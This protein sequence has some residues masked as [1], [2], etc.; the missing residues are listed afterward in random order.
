MQ[1]RQ[2]PSYYKN[3]M[4]ICDVPLCLYMLYYLLLYAFMVLFMWSYTLLV[5]D[6]GCFQY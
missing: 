3:C 5:K 2:L 4:T 1:L 6:A